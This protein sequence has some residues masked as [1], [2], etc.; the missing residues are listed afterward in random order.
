MSNKRAPVNPHGESPPRS[1]ARTAQHLLEPADTQDENP[2]NM[3]EP[4]GTVDQ[5]ILGLVTKQTK[6]LEKFEEDRRERELIHQRDREVL[7]AALQA[8]TEGLRN[9]AV[10]SGQAS[11][12][13]QNAA[14]A[15]AAAQTA[16]ETA[17]QH[18]NDRPEVQEIQIEDEEKAWK[19]LNKTLPNDI[20]KLMKQCISDTKKD[21]IIAMK[22]QT[23]I[24]FTLQYQ[25]RR[26]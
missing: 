6:L 24:L 5:A 10:T 16:L 19:D 25:R 3:A 2:E 26:V 8:A 21:L 14:A 9:A 7:T 4:M 18:Q 12:A 13:A 22:T 1:G 11:G 17:A 20:V 23:K 15:A